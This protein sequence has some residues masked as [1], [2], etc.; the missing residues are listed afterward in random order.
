MKK[1]ID[2]IKDDFDYVFLDCLPSLGLIT[3]NALSAS[4][5]V[6]IPTIES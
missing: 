1:V 6:L 5:A 2:K 3:V 4:D